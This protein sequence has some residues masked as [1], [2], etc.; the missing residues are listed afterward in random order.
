MEKQIRTEHE[1]EFSKNDVEN[2][3]NHEKSGHSEPQNSLEEKD[4]N[5]PSGSFTAEEAKVLLYNIKK[6]NKEQRRRE[7]ELKEKIE[8]LEFQLDKMQTINSYDGHTNPGQK[9]KHLL[10]IKEE[11]N[12][13]KK[14]LVKLF[15]ENRKLNENSSNS[16]ASNKLKFYEAKAKKYKLELEKLRKELK[17]TMYKTSKFCDYILS[18]PSLPESIT[19]VEGET[20]KMKQAIE[21]IT[22]LARLSMKKEKE[23]SEA[24]REKDQIQFMLDAVKRERDYLRKNLENVAKTDFE[25]KKSKGQVPQS[26]P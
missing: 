26:A 2:N 15:N 22:Y 21:A 6:Q 9:I 18:R 24:A 10:K 19:K 13:L 7:A 3:E 23:M 11:N 25:R 5:T 12:Q 14:E 8:D 1:E 4:V 17:E 16:E 20:T